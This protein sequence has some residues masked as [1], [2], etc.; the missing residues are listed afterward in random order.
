MESVN[1][2]NRE[3][4]S[5]GNGRSYDKNVLRSLCDV[6]LF[7]TDMSRGEFIFVRSWLES[8]QRNRIRKASDLIYGYSTDINTGQTRMLGQLF[9]DDPFPFLIFDKVITH[10]IKNL[11]GETPLEQD[12]RKWKERG[13][14]DHG[15]MSIERGVDRFKNRKTAI[16]VWRTLV[17]ALKG[18]CVEEFD[19]VI[20]S[21]YGLVIDNMSA[22][23][24]HE[25]I[26]NGDLKISKTNDP[27]V[28]NL[29]YMFPGLRSR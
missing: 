26:I 11:Y 2:P 22:H 6:P 17:D 7:P 18:W 21:G 28:L 14:F 1:P 10:E 27:T 16:K 13:N 29:Y 15:M 4:I 25:A 9:V 8:F 12:F 19:Y 24:Q 20:T 3:W 5:A 23:E